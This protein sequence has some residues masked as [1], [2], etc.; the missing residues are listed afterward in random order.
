M[1]L[2]PNIVLPAVAAAALLLATFICVIGLSYSPSLLIEGSR[3]AAGEGSGAGTGTGAG[4]VSEEV[5]VDLPDPDPTPAGPET[6]GLNPALMLDA[7]EHLVDIATSDPAVQDQLAAW[8]SFRV[9]GISYQPDRTGAGNYTA[10]TFAPGT[11]DQGQAVTVLVNY[12][13]QQVVEVREGNGSGNTT[14]PDD[15]TP[16]K[17][18]GQDKQKDKNDNPGHDDVNGGGK[19]QEKE[20]QNN[21]NGNGDGNGSG[22]DKDKDKDKENQNNGNGNG[23]GNG[24]PKATAKPGK[25]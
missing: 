5:S 6:S 18:Q 3:A 4:A 23:N 17:G 15:R 11:G 25:K 8:G 22:K 9:A 7:P 2:S 21:G 20:N 12:E 19:G 16:G 13:K 1:R 10:V 14:R 24:N